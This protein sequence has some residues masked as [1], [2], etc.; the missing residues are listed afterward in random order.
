M[1]LLIVLTLHKFT[2]FESK[3]RPQS[4]DFNFSRKY[5]FFPF[6]IVKSFELWNPIRA[7]L[8]VKKPTILPVLCAPRFKWTH[9]KA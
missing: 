8:F 2:N 7:Y 6:Q 1:R 4:D 3:F 9:S 5:V